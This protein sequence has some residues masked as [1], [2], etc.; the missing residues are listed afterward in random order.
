VGLLCSRLLALSPTGHLRWIASLNGIVAG[1]PQIGASGKAVYVTHNAKS[2]I[3][4]TYI[5]G[6]LSVF[7]DDLLGI[8]GEVPLQDAG[9]FGYASKE[10]PFS[11]PAVVVSYSSLFA[12]Q[13][14][15]SEAWDNGQAAFGLMY[16]FNSSSYQVSALSRTSSSSIVAPLLSTNGTSMF[17]GGR[18]STIYG[19]PQGS[20]FIMKPNWSQRIGTDGSGG[21]FR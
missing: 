16:Q 14:Y 17:L 4:G 2:A 5:A 15:W 12:D 13:V 8:G 21:K 19:W 7:R 3:S 1:T 9:A 11:P 6:K 20:S 10:A 18:A